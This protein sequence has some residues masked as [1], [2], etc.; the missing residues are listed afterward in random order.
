VLLLLLLWQPPLAGS[1]LATA[2]QGLQGM[3][4]QHQQQ[5]LLGMLSLGLMLASSSSSS[6]VRVSSVSSLPASQG[7]W[8]WCL[9]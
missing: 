8:R 7:G 6:R 9:A 1:G 4:Q 2:W 5:A 3:R